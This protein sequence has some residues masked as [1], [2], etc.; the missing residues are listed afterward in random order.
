[1]TEVFCILIRVMTTWVHM[2]IKAHGISPLRSLHRPG[3][4]SSPL[5]SPASHAHA[6][7]L[8]TSIELQL[9]GWF[10]LMGI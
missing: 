10:F 2:F 1:M 8:K 6:H 9:V 5:L 4:K 3:C 7:I